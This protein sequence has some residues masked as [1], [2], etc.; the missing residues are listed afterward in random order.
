MYR[1]PRF[2]PTLAISVDSM[3]RYY[4]CGWML[5][6]TA[7]ETQ[8]LAWD[9]TTGWTGVALSHT[10]REG[11]DGLS[12]RPYGS[13]IQRYDGFSQPA[14]GVFHEGSDIQS[15]PTSSG[16]IPIR[17]IS[18]LRWSAAVASPFSVLTLNA[19]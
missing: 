14:I 1:Q 4:L 11:S 16:M 17:T 6:A 2:L 12:L 9:S 19:P 8:Q 15:Y 10:V 7:G 3:A 5:L 13:L 18:T